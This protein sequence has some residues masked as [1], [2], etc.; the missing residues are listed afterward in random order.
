M[1]TAKLWIGTSWKMN[2]TRDEALT[3]AS[4]VA[5]QSFPSDMQPFVIPP[6][7]SI[8]V[9]AE[10]LAATNVRIGAQNIH[11]ADAGAWTGEVSASMVR[12]CGASLVE[13]GHSER[14]THF[15]DTDGR[16]AQ[17]VAAAL[18]HGLT[19]LIC[20][21]ET[22]ADRANGQADRVLAQQVRAALSGVA[23]EHR[24][25]TV[26]LAYEPVWSIGEGGTP[27]SAAY[28][29]ARHAVIAEVARAA[30]GRSVPCLYGG[31][32]NA[33]NCR[34]YVRQPDIDGLFIGRAAW[35]AEDYLEIVGRCADA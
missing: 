5:P 19:P 9:V 30:T 29:Q 23:P 15:G 13:L 2:K 31:S 26:L 28:A 14:R 34:D 3:W 16:V 11:W 10:A 18:R 27:A 33:G 17:K 24:Q 35:Q 1:A 21:G 7:T 12:D 20:I 4:A 32:V 25:A 6:Y 22:A 8:A